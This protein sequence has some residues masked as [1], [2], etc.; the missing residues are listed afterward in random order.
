VIPDWNV[1]QNIPF[2]VVLGVFAAV[3]FCS[4]LAITI[5][6]RNKGSAGTLYYNSLVGLLTSFA[7]GVSMTI[8]ASEYNTFTRPVTKDQTVLPTLMP[9]Y[10]TL[11]VDATATFLFSVPMLLFV[12]YHNLEDYLKQ[13]R[14]ATQQTFLQPQALNKQ[15]W[16]LALFLLN[17]FAHA[18][19]SRP[20][21]QW[22]STSTSSRASR[23]KRTTV[24]TTWR[25]STRST[26]RCRWW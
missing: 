13:Q 23:T 9:F 3:Q 10:Y 11:Q 2:A 21:T 1:K 8:L 22:S 5:T 20:P 24:W 4:S 6:N 26:C 16:L 18:A 12:F 25:T 15:I 17:S 19:C 14:E 7:V